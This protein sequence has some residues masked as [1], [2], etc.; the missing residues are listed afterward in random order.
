MLIYSLVFLYT[1]IPLEYIPILGHNKPWEDVMSRQIRDS[2]STVRKYVW[3]QVSPPA[4][5]NSLRGKEL[6]EDYPTEGV[7]NLLWFKTDT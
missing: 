2:K 6:R 4:Y 5:R 7:H 3:V 1:T